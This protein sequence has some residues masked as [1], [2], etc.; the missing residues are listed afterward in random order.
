MDKWIYHQKKDNLY[1]AKVFHNRK[2]YYVGGFKKKADA[3]KARDC[4]IEEILAGNTKK[5]KSRTNSNP[6]K[7]SSGFNFDFSSSFL[8]E[9]EYRLRYSVLMCALDDICKSSE[10]PEYAKSRNW[11]LGKTPSAKTFSFDEICE[12]FH[13]NPIAVREKVINI[14]E[15]T[16]EKIKSAIQ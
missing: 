11:I 2:E 14:D 3:I 16:K 6:R 15:K 13:L 7:Q 9:P 1:I 8:E 10:H 4:A 12:L 5:Y